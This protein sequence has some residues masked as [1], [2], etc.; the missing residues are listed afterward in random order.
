M[1]I[2]LQCVPTLRLVTR[3]DVRKMLT[4]IREKCHENPVRIRK[5]VICGGKIRKNAAKIRKKC[6]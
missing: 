2:R 1:I 5:N 6:C 3:H 4:K